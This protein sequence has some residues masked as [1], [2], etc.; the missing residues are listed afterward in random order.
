MYVDYG[1]RVVEAEAGCGGDGGGG[2]AADLLSSRTN[3]SL[4]VSAPAGYL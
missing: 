1:R 3:S 2:G 4:P